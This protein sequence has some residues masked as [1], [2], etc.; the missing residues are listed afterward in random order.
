MSPTALA[1]AFAVH[2]RSDR[3][4]VRIIEACGG[5]DFYTAP[6]LRRSVL[7]SVA[8]GDVL[9]VLDLDRLE[10]LDSTGLSVFIR[11]LK[12]CCGAGGALAI[13]RLP[14]RPEHTLRTAGVLTLFDLYDTV[15]AAEDALAPVSGSRR[16][17]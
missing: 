2:T 11:A 9:I 6:M 5:L 7:E 13:A 1:A 4:G 10:F 14:R 17:R 3:Q 8:E 12:V 15:D 16:S